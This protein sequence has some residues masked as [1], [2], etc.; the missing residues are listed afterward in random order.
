M[1]FSV[2]QYTYVTLQLLSLSRDV[3]PNSGFVDLSGPDSIQ[4]KNKNPA[5]AT[6]LRADHKIEILPA[7]PGRRS[8]RTFA[9][10][11]TILLLQ[12][13][14]ILGCWRYE[15]QLQVHAVVL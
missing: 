8:P 7:R 9:L 14:P 4:Y 12:I 3:V 2:G 10:V 11:F 1:S 6:V 5:T 13:P 15:F